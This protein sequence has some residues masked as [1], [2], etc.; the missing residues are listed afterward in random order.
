MIESVGIMSD[1]YERE[2]IRQRILERYRSDPKIR[3]NVS[4]AQPKLHLS[5]V[6][7]E[8]TGVYAHIF[9]IEENSSGQAKRHTLS[10]ADVLTHNIEILDP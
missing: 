5:N 4:I 3:I 8:I 1:N 10:Y 6:P 2:Q 7:V 9:Q